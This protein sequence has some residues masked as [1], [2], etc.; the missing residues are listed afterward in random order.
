MK[1]KVSQE[2]EGRNGH[3]AAFKVPS[4]PFHT[5]Q[6]SRR[7][8]SKSIRTQDHT[9]RL[10]PHASVFAHHGSNLYP[11]TGP[12][13]VNR[14]FVHSTIADG[15][16]SLRVRHTVPRDI[17]RLRIKKGG[18][19]GGGEGCPSFHSIIF[20]HHALHQRTQNCRIWATE[21]S[22]VPALMETSH[23]H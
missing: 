6:G 12:N 11:L 13:C 17:T 9:L 19:E 3:F 4:K 5:T 20:S 23:S 7:A 15:L 18:R 14:D 1:Q 21:D 2:I 10:Y 22:V 8:G 16:I